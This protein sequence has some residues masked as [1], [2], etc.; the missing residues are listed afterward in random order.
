MKEGCLYFVFRSFFSFDEQK[1]LVREALDCH[2]MNSGDSNWEDLRISTSSRKLALGISTG[3]DLTSTLPFAVA[4]ARKAFRK[5]F[6]KKDFEA[7]KEVCREDAPLTGLALLYGP[8]ASMPAHYDSPTQPGQREEWLA[9][10]TVGNTVSFRCNDDVLE[11]KSGDVVVFDSMAVLHGVEGVAED[12]VDYQRLGLPIA[13]RL[14]TL[15]WQGRM[16]LNNRSP[17]T[18]SVVDGVGNLFVES[19]CE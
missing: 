19:D 10:A 13:S 5:V 11:L 1:K 7:L 9:L 17:V 18:A 15:F 16:K 12:D 6:E 8:N 2:H 4:L 14:G 3:G